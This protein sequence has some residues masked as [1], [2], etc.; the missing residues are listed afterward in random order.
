ME[1]KCKKPGSTRRFPSW[2]ILDMESW[3]IRQSIGTY[4]Y[5]RIE[6]CPDPKDPHLYV[7]TITRETSTG[8]GT[9]YERL[10]GE[11][12]NDLIEALLYLES[13]DLGDYKT[14]LTSKEIERKCKKPGRRFP[15]WTF[16]ELASCHIQQ[17]DGTYIYAT[18]DNY[19]YQKDPHPYHA[20]IMRE[21]YTGFGSDFKLLKRESFDDLV[22]A[23][24]YLEGVDLNEY[25]LNAVEP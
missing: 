7:A 24:L 23:L 16:L 25:N 5:G 6:N 10:K 22:E 9:R 8:S 21:V 14:T 18:V 11:S 3:P 19:Q 4:I 15:A 12:F 17:S 1:R 2:S 13:V 20:E